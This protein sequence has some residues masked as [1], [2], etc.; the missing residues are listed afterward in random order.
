MLG[1]E[2]G[3][4][5]PR[6]REQAES[7]MVDE[8][9]I[10]YVSGTTWDEDSGTSTPTYVTRYSGKCR[11]Q[12]TLTSESQQGAGERKW[13]IQSLTVS[14]PMSVTGVAVGDRVTITDTA[15]DL[16]LVGRVFTVVALA[17]KTH[18]TARRL[19]VEEVTA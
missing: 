1:H 9:K 18:M 10:E 15:L 5:L 17:H 2:I 14:V 19:R 12:T 7:L 3:A 13:T 4:A 11:A 6:L 8:C 16:D